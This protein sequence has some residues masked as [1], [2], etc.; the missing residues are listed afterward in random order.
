MPD[1]MKEVIKCGACG[2]PEYYGMMHWK[3]SMQ[4]CRSCIYDI[5]HSLNPEWNPSPHDYLFPLYVDG[6]DYREEA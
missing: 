3:N 1:E 2:K 4:L 6:K 5:W